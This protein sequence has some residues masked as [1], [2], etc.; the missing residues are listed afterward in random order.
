MCQLK[1]P[2]KSDNLVESRFPDCLSGKPALTAAQW[3]EGQ[4][5]KPLR[6]PILEKSEEDAY[7]EL[8][9]EKAP[10]PELIAL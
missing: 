1:F 6:R 7:E 4:N 5:A 10:N 9:V 3:N 2:K 8:V